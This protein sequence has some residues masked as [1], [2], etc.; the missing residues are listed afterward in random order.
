CYAVER[1]KGE[2]KFTPIPNVL[3]VDQFG[4]KT[5]DVLAPTLLCLPA[6]KNNEAPGAE[7][8]PGH[9]L[10]YQTKHERDNFEKLEVFTNDQFGPRDLRIIRREEFCVPS[11][12]Q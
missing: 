11:V 6:D 9:L 4:T 12:V 2:P 3:L 5:V 7:N 10:C 8:H 1:S